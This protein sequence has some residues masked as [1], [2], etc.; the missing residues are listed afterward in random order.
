MTHSSGCEIDT[1]DDS[2]NCGACDNDCADEPNVTAADCVVSACDPTPCIH[3][4][5]SLWRKLVQL[6]CQWWLY[7]FAYIIVIVAIYIS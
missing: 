4:G 2:L 5:A 6:R 3:A 7:M 1:R